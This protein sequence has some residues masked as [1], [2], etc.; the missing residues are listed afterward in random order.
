MSC[1]NIILLIRRQ[2]DSD[3]H[4][5]KTGRS[6]GPACPHLSLTHSLLCL[7]QAINAAKHG[8]VGV[9]VYTDPADINDGKSLPSETFPNSWGL[10]PSGV[11]RG[12]YY[13]YFGDPL[14]PYL[15][16]HPSS[17][18]LDLNNI[19]G[20]PPIPAQPIGFEDAKDLL[21]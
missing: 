8:V 14:T 16:A 12:S 17:F 19:S 3:F 5:E 6:V 13:E 2:S 21:W 11:E 7:L 15:P 1:A 9:L 18:R 10:P 20:F 4:V